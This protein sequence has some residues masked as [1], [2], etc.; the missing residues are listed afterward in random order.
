MTVKKNNLW[1]SRF[2]VLVFSVLFISIFARLTYDLQINEL[3]IPI[4]GQTFAV[5]LIPFIFGRKIGMIAIVTYLFLGGLGLPL[6]ADGK[7]GFEV[8]KG[9][10]AGF[11]YGFV[12]ATWI[13]GA[14]GEQGWGR[15]LAKSNL[16]MFLGTLVIMTSGVAWL[17]YAYGFE[18]GMEYG[19]YPFIPGAII[20]I[21][22]GGLIGWW[23]YQQKYFVST[24]RKLRQF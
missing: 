14:L 23:I 4:T 2:I 1:V 22:A 7:S 21:I 12:I 3:D 20:K 6:F 16:V 10:S 5:L 8:F 17:T 24:L 19:C 13:V 18:K 15:T 11:L 9:G